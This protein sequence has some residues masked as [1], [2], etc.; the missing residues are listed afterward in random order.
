MFRRL[1]W[2]ALAAL[3]ALC[4]VF[5]ACGSSDD[6][7]GATSADSGAAATT[8]APAAEET[9]TSESTGAV[10][11]D[12]DAAEFEGGQP[13]SGD[14]VK[15]GYISLGDQV[16]FVKLV[17]DGIKAQARRAGANLVF[18]DSQ[19]DAAKALDCAKNFK[20]Q[21]VDVIVNFQVDE[22]AAPNI[23]AAGPDVPT[24][25]V[26]INQRPC[27]VSFMGA[28]NQRA[29]EMAGTAMG[30]Y[31]R[32]N[33]DCEYDA[34]VSMQQPAA[35]VVNEQRSG[36]ALRGFEAVCGEIDDSKLKIVDGGGTIEGGQRKFADVLTSLPGQDKIIVL[37]LNDDMALGSLAAAKSQ[38]RDKDL[39]LA[40]QGADP[41]AHCEIANNP[42]WVGDAAYFP[43]R[44]GE[45][46]VPNAI[47][48]ARGEEV[49]PTLYVPH[50]LV[51]A[52]NIS[53]FYEVR[54]C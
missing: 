34:V 54:G 50:T 29:G 17:S 26:D 11:D 1:K 9:R 23:C 51:N 31:F 18:C 32:A 37:S 33:D 15:I 48:A 44:Y 2:V 24:I 38:G 40:G 27:Q 39:Y 7:G 20:T 47:R 16:P 35:G 6:D 36:G 5:A 21:N 45:I 10:P 43:E 41:S 4:V 13:G 19:V 22:K 3:A 28:N 42:Q 14:G 12:P 30:E 46:L 25:A 52:D 49:S 8:E 53:E